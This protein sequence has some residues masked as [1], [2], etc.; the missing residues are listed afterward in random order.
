MNGKVQTNIY[1]TTELRHGLG[2]AAATLDTSITR[3]VEDLV[4]QHLDTYV[5]AK[6]AEKAP[7]AEP[8]KV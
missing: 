2:L 8:P 1:L 3:I 4:L 6:Q 5:A 7:R